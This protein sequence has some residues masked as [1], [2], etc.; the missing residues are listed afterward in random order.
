MTA[1]DITNRAVSA[2]LITAGG[3]TP[4]ASM[5]AALYVEALRAKSRVKKIALLGPSRAKRGSVR[6]TL[7][8][9]RAAPFLVRVRASHRDS[10]R[11]GG[12]SARRT[13]SWGWG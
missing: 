8:P 5:S 7:R 10:D 11:H 9:P 4:E 12:L 3:R 2:G 1:A 13:P 6:W